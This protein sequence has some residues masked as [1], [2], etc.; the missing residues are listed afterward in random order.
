MG[1]LYHGYVSHN[2]RVY[3]LFYFDDFPIFPNIQ[4]ENPH[5]ITIKIVGQKCCRSQI[6]RPIRAREWP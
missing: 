5:E 4:D 1:H 6:S 2:Q 3:Q